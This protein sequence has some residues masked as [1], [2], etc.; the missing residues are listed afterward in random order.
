MKTQFYPLIAATLLAFSLPSG[1]SAQ[2]ERGA[3]KPSAAPST[4]PS[5]ANQFVNGLEKPNRP[6]QAT[7][8]MNTNIPKYDQ[9]HTPIRWYAIENENNTKYW[10]SVN[11]NRIWLVLDEGRSIN[12]SEISE[13]LEEYQL[14]KVISESRI[15][16]HINYWI[17]EFEN[18]TPE[19]VVS[20]AK[21]ASDIDGIKYLEPSVIYTTM[22]TPNDPLYNVQWGPYV[23]YF[24]DAWDTSIGGDSWNVVCIIDD[25]CDWYHEDL[26]DQVWYGWDYA[27]DDGDIYPDD[28]TAHKHGTHVTGTVAATINNGIGVAGMIND[29]VYFA[30]VGNPDGSLSDEGIL[31]AYYDIGNISRITAVNMSFGG[32]APSAAQEQGCNYAW[33]NGKILVVSSGNEGTGIISYP[34][35]YEACMAVGAIGSNG[36]QLYLASYSQYGNEQEICAPGGDSDFGYGIVSCIP[37]NQYEP[38]DGTSMAAPHVAGLAGLIKHVNMDLTNADIRN[39]INATAIDLGTAGWDQMYGYGMINASAAI[40]VAL[41]ASVGVAELNKTEVL[42]IYP[43][44]A[45]NNILIDKKVEF[46]EGTFQILD[47]SGKVVKTIENSDQKHTNINISELPQGVYLLHMSSEIGATTSRFVKL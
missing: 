26:T 39:I 46:Q 14:T 40:Q 11:T 30:K 7:Y 29:T 38:M 3:R 12:E 47:I 23:A 24:D 8:Q 5:N 21:A 31:N 13:F 16:E 6:D 32:P 28:P 9:I 2:L 37:Q 20:A 35:K 18:S 42:R 36:Q 22:Y 41:N 10:E 19:R 25:A 1:A 27:Q 44:P 4:Q 17:F 33:N 34:A 43:N 15:K 45:T